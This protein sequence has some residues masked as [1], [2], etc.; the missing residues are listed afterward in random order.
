MMLIVH[1]QSRIGENCLRA[2]RCRGQQRVP[3]GLVEIMDMLDSH[4]HAL[5]RHPLNR[6]M[7]M[8]VGHIRQK[9][10]VATPPTR[11]ASSDAAGA[12]ANHFLDG[13]LPLDQH[14]LGWPAEGPLQARAINEIWEPFLISPRRSDRR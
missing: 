2:H 12:P 14:T 6:D 11:R 3:A 7:A 1:A 4:T 5:G 10:P 9:F 13:A 8:V